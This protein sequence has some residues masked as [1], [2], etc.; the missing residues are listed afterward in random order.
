MVWTV[1]DVT[2]DNIAWL[3]A[4]TT[5]VNDVGDSIAAESKRMVYVCV[6]SVGMK[7]K[8]EAEQIGLKLEYKFILADNTEYDGEQIIEFNGKR[9]NIVDVYS[10][11]DNKLELLVKRF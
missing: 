4:Q 6:K 10:A 2:F 3:I 7:R 11:P 9:Y 5:T 1:I 8:I